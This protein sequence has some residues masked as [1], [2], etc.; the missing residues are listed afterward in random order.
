M[1]DVP[2]HLPHHPAMD[3]RRFLVTSLA[4]A[5]A[6]PFAAEA[7]P[8]GELAHITFFRSGPPP[9]AFVEA[10]QQGLR[11]V[12]Y[13]EGKTITPIRGWN[14]SVARSCTRDRQAKARRHSRLSRP[15]RPRRQERNDRDPDRLRRYR[16][17]CRDRLG[18][19]LGST[20]RKHH[21][22]QHSSVDLLGKPLE[23]LK[24]LVPRLSSVALLWNPT[25]PTRAARLKHAERMTREL[26]VRFQMLSIRARGLRSGVGG[27]A[28]RPLARVVRSRRSLGIRAPISS[29]ATLEDDRYG[30]SD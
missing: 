13:V 11:E 15:R 12:G 23:L 18:G 10:F 20:R 29:R 27:R 30:N 1:R 24:E 26:G 28:G 5:H 8:A 2:E 16:R 14:G 4:G 3:R 6:A 22:N 17:S 19:Q 9:Q 25:N 7:Q 21:R